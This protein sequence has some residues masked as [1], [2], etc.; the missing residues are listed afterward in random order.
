VAAV[1]GGFSYLTDYQPKNPP[2]VGF[3]E[4]KFTYGLPS[5]S[6]FIRPKGIIHAYYSRA[7][8]PDIGLSSYEYILLGETLEPT[9]YPLEELKIYPGLGAEKAFLKNCAYSEKE[10]IARKKQ[11]DETHLWY[12]TSA[13]IELDRFFGFLHPALKRSASMSGK[14]YFNSTYFQS[15]SLDL[16]GDFATA[17]DSFLSFSINAM[18]L[19]GD[20]PFYRETAVSGGSFR[21]FAGRGYYTHRSVKWEQEFRTSVYRDRLYAGPFLDFTIFKGSGFDLSGIQSGAC[22]GGAV[23]LVFLDQFEFSVY[24]GKDYLFSTGESG[25][26]FNF[27]IEKK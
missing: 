19:T 24:A 3:I 25:M 12:V 5:I 1:S 10:S 21:G 15:L 2:S 6:E 9:V 26:V 27:G 14:A 4:G 22:G 23:H 16:H 18:S 20:V 13:R 8:R 11:N 7:S 17:A